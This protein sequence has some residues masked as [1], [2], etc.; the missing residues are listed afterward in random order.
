[1]GQARGDAADALGACLSPLTHTPVLVSHL[2]GRV[3]A[4]AGAVLFERFDLAT[5]LDAVERHGVTELPL[6]GGMVFDVVHA[7]SVPA[8]VRRTVRKVSVGGA[9]TP[10]EAKR[11]LADIFAGAEIIEA[12]GQTES[13]DGVTMARGPSVFEREGTGG[14]MNPYGAV[15]AGRGGRRRPRRAG[16]LRR[17]AAGRLQEAAPHRVRDRAAA[18]RRQQGRDRPAPAAVRRLMETLAGLLDATVTRFPARE[19][20]AYAPHGE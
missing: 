11:A 8:A 17:G 9:P 12:Y 6:I 20:L 10:M 14:R 2:L 1:C 5:V 19:A 7:G 4:G 15:P 16:R 13:T 18:E 3:L